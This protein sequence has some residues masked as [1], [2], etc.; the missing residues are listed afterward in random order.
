M[1]HEVNLPETIYDNVYTHGQ[2]DSLCSARIIRQFSHVHKS[3]AFA[4]EVRKEQADDPLL[5]FSAIQFSLPSSRKG[6]PFVSPVLRVIGDGCGRAAIYTEGILAD[7]DTTKICDTFQPSFRRIFTR[8]PTSSS[9]NSRIFHNLPAVAH[10]EIHGVFTTHISPY[11]HL[12]KDRTYRESSYIID[13]EDEGP[14]ILIDVAM[15]EEKTQDYLRLFC[16]PSRDDTRKPFYIGS[17]SRYKRHDWIVT[18]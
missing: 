4:R 10:D 14:S 8:N 11:L 3:F 17:I 12:G 1:I 18:H 16:R 7:E 6:T 2:A 9:V 13:L 5:N 15:F